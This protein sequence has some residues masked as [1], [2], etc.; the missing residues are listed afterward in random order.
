M[1]P[2]FEERKAEL[3]E[4][5]E[6]LG[7]KRLIRFSFGNTHEEVEPTDA[8]REKAPRIT[9]WHRWAMFLTLSDGAIPIERYIKS[10]T[11]HLHPT[12]KVSE[13][14]VTVPPFIMSR[15]A[16]GYFDVTM[17]IEFQPSTGIGMKKLVHGL[18]FD[19]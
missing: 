18:C 7:N 3:Q 11:Y 10:V 6:W 4:A 16:W 17:D 8:Q 9:V 2:A 15:L 13:I 1:G 5:G 19:G 14:K 12:Y